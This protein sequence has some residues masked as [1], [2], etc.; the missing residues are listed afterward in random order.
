MSEHLVHIEA[1]DADEVRD[2]SLAKAISEELAHVYPNH[3]WV[4]SFS[5]HNLIIRHPLI[6][7]LIAL[8]TGREGFASLLPRDKI[9]TVHE[10]CKTAV[11]FA[12]ALLEA[13]C[14]PRGPWNG[15]DMP[16][17]PDD[18]NQTIKARRQIKGY[19]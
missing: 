14:L 6:A 1:G 15:T 19:H 11:K 9:G 4:V 8:Q 13:F 7:N 2:L 17:V 16:V 5:G 3:F 12:G 10:A 18:L